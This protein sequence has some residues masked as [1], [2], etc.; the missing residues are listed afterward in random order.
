MVLF[1]YPRAFITALF[2][3]KSEKARKT[4]K[5]FIPTPT[6]T[7]TKIKTLSKIVFPVQPREHLQSC[8]A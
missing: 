7:S 4:Q 3:G 8:K 2:K 6:I 1:A 5:D